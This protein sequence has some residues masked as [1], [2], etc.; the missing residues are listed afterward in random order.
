MR[1]LKHLFDRNRLWAAQMLEQ[2]PQF[3]QKLVAQQT[4]EYL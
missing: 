4:P 3:F 2:D 1:F